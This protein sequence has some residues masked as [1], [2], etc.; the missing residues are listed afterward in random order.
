MNALQD[1]LSTNKESSLSAYAA[2]RGVEWVTIPPRAPHFGGLWE[3]AVKSCKIL[4]RSIG[5][6]ALTFEELSTVLA[7]VEACLNSRPLTPMSHDPNDMEVL[8]PGH[9]Q[10]G[11]PLHSLPTES[12]NAPPKARFTL[13]TR[14]KLVQQIHDSFW[15]RWYLSN[16]QQHDKWKLDTQPLQVSDLVLIKEDRVP[17]LHWPRARILNLYTGN[18]GTARVARVQTA[19]GIF[20]RPLTKLVKLFFDE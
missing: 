13:H 12:S 9:F 5:L 14:L 18:D 4:R 3:A 16:L 10:I 20:T 17:P 1:L 6:Q 2:T 15:S 11:A 7:H 19:N 8:S